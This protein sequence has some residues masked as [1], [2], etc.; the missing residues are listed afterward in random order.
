M[1]KYRKLLIVLLAIIFPIIIISCSFKLNLPCPISLK[2]HKEIETGNRIA[3]IIEK[4]K[5]IN[6][7]YPD[8]TNHV[9]IRRIVLQAV[10]NKKWTYEPFYPAYNL[11]NSYFTLTYVLGFE[12]P[13]LTYNSYSKYWKIE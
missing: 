7:S 12:G 2:Y 4:H 13:Y 11:H 5:L 6:G 3:T 8:S 9:L 1:F 10:N